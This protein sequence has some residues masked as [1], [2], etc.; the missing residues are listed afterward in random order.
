RNGLGRLG[1]LGLEPAARYERSRPGELVHIDVKK[2]GRISRGAGHRV[3]GGLQHYTGRHLD[4]AGRLRGSAGW[5][6]VPIAV[7]DHSPAAPPPPKSPPTKKPAPRPLPPAAPASSSS[8]TASR[9]SEPSPTTAA[10]TSLPCTRSLANDSASATSAPGRADRKQTARQSASSA[11]SSPAGPTARSTT[12]A[13]NAQPPLTAGSGTTTID[14]N[15]QPSAANPRSAEP[16]CLGPTSSRR[17]PVS[18]VPSAEYILILEQR[19]AFSTTS[20]SGSKVP[21]AAPSI[22]TFLSARSARKPAS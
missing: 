2:L 14:D 1:R 3:H 16:T 19:R 8:A 22:S 5:E 21:S 6:F 18:L 17:P 9:S 11:P 13:T 7:D 20:S 15:T 10:P 12:Q 4:A